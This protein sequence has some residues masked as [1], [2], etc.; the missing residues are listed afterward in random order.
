MT[1]GGESGLDQ[2]P[3]GAQGAPSVTTLMPA[4]ARARLALAGVQARQVLGAALVLL[5]AAW[6]IA[7]WASQPRLVQ[8]DL[9][10]DDLAEGRVTGYAVVLLREDRS[11]MFDTSPAVEVWPAP[12]D[13]RDQVSGAAA[14]VDEWS[15]ADG[16]RTIAYWVDSRG[17][18]LRVLDPDRTFPEELST[19]ADRF[20]EAGIE[21]RT[22]WSWSYL[23]G[24]GN[25]GGNALSLLMLVGLVIVVVG[26]RPGR[27]NRWCWF[28]LLSL[29]LGLGVLA[30]A[31]SELLRP[32]RLVVVPEGAT[33]GDP[34]ASELDVVPK[35]LSGWAGFW[36]TILGAMLVTVVSDQLADLMPLLF[37]RA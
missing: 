6:L 7:L 19:L 17:A 26:P 13:S 8:P 32:P 29:P 2:G 23:I 4:L 11:G 21:D 37:V 34:T 3:S 9:L 1:T 31:V 5:W 20:D 33:D 35:R 15:P 36:I 22:A 16:L 18:D 28:W 27:G 14:D 25:G 24:S 30:F 12:E 10:E